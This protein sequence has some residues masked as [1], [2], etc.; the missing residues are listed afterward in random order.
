MESASGEKIQACHCPCHKM[1]GF[2]VILIG[3]TVLLGTFE[4]LS[5]KVVG[6]VWPIFL[7]L[8]GARASIMR[9]MCKC[10]DK[11]KCE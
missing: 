11:A 3:I 9:G 4:V 1:I 10:C 2:M 7:I 6:I 8:A 5:A